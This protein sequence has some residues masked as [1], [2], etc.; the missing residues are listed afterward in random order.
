MA[1]ENPGAIV[2]DFRKEDV[3]RI[4]GNPRTPVDWHNVID[5][6][7]RFN[8]AHKR[9]GV[10]LTIFKPAERMSLEADSL[11]GL[12]K[13]ASS[14]RGKRGAK[15]R[16]FGA[17]LL[18]KLLDHK[19]QYASFRDFQKAQRDYL[20]K[21][22]A[23]LLSLPFLSPWHDI[24]VDV[25]DGGK[26]RAVFPLESIRR[27]VLSHEA[28]QIL[29]MGETSIGKTTLFYRSLME[30]EALGSRNHWFKFYPVYVPAS[31]ISVKGSKGVICWE[32]LPCGDPFFADRLEALF[33][34][35]KLLL[36]L[37]G[38]ERNPA[39]FDF[40]NPATFSFWNLASR[41]RL[42]LACSP[43]FYET[44]VRESPLRKLLFSTM[45][46]L[47]L[48]PWKPEDFK[49]FYEKLSSS[50]KNHGNIALADQFRRL[51][52]RFDDYIQ[53][54]SLIRMT[55]LTAWALAKCYLDHSGIFPENEYQLLDL[56]IGSAVN[57]EVSQGSGFGNA[58]ALLGFFM[59]I[60]WLAYVEEKRRDRAWVVPLETVE[61]M[62]AGRHPHW[63]ERKQEIFL[64][65][66]RSPLLD[67]DEET[68]SFH[69]GA[70]FVE[71]LA[72]RYIIKKFTE[73]DLSAL[74]EIFAVPMAAHNLWRYLALG[75]GTLRGGPADVFLKSAMLLHDSLQNK[76]RA[77]PNFLLEMAMGCLLQSL[78]K[79]Q[80]ARIQSFLSGIANPAR[81]IPIYI[82][83]SAAIGGAYSGDMD[84]FER[85][86]KFL[87]INP[88]ARKRIC[89]IYLWAHY[90]M[91]QGTSFEAFDEKEIY[92][93]SRLAD[94]ILASLGS[95]DIS[96]VHPFL[97]LI[98][99]DLLKT[100]VATP[101][102]SA[103]VNSD[104]A[105]RNQRLRETLSRPFPQNKASGA[106][107]FMI[108]YVSQLKES[109]AKNVLIKEN[110]P[111]E[112][113]KDVQSREKEIERIFH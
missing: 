94:W 74:E 63:A 34:D 43:R 72:A 110:L 40:S 52:V 100:R 27:L 39:L 12:E 35:G 81:Q 32:S 45:E 6:A 65:L 104:I 4:F 11:Y 33:R 44:H 96:A 103:H 41:N 93:W 24:P 48:S 69:M 54:N 55:P 59:K 53:R 102:K 107:L 57:H 42:I 17:C 60:A 21:E 47:P 3:G 28:R 58:Q 84:S 64:S 101:F 95:P 26:L 108:G 90:G 13:A 31:H 19:Q 8:K 112:N 76:Y 79:L 10:K 62:L 106:S 5:W 61:K 56:I 82:A 22:T 18:S 89:K 113:E 46:I 36:M 50:A 80:H 91:P 14:T 86:I 87:K 105:G 20:M 68:A 111:H 37:D 2:I 85:F 77:Q 88:H 51:S 97:F 16:A 49:A 70:H 38:L 7:S 29:F 92:D 75:I 78:G 98:L 9:L 15:Q 30:I 83:L 71:F 23:P 73:S 99:N 67:Y 66:V 109:I 1:I 25:L